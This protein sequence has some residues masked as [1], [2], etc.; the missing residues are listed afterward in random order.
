M[1]GLCLHLGCVCVDVSV[2]Y[3]ND[4]KVQRC[5]G[6]GGLLYV[7]K[8]QEQAA[9]ISLSLVHRGPDSP[10]KGTWREARRVAQGPC[11]GRRRS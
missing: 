11:R 2:C 1:S 5:L 10:S 9:S 4:H 3:G 6:R 8:A 7:Q